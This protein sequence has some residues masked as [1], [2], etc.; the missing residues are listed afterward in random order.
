MST[1][2]AIASL[3]DLS[4]P[5]RRGRVRLRTLILMRWVAVAGQASAL[6]I[7][8]FVLGYRLPIW[9]ALATVAASAI[10]NLWAVVGRRPPARIGDR[11]AAL[12]FAYDLVQL[13][14]LLYL[15]G[16]LNNPFAIIILAPVTVSATILSRRSTLG[17]TL[18][19]L[20][21]VAVLALF[22]E[23][24][25]WPDGS[26][27]LQ[28]LFILG[29][30]LAL[31]LALVFFALYVFSVSEE[32]RRMSDALSATQMA[33]SREQRLSALGG[34]AAAAAHGLGSPLGTIAVI[35]KELDRDLPPD[36]PLRPDVELLLSQSQRCRDIL[37]QLATRPEGD[38]APPFGPL[39]L[40]ELVH[41]AAMPH[42]IE[43]VNLVIDAGP[44]G[45]TPLVA[46]S[47]ELLHGLANLIQNAIQFARREVRIAIRGSETHIIVRIVDD[48][49]GFDPGLLDHLGE[50][51]LSGRGRGRDGEGEDMGL[52]I[53][54]AQTLLEHTGAGLRFAN[55][56]TGGAEV[57]VTWPRAAL[58]AMR[59]SS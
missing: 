24:L 33:L 31:A 36:S 23:P 43:R 22:H 1:M 26:F 17:L 38:A 10:V 46:R 7:V 52:G 14:V 3:R 2:T 5:G 53:F 18:L 15:T 42:R 58:A 4:A 6:V 20:A 40:A 32:A 27:A 37:A 34:L 16:G 56:P 49:P 9:W 25:P 47:P 12:Y 44:E 21:I 30:A 59:Q 13:A 29:L 54:I 50:P 51:Y 39:P 45:G 57:E 19:A 48:G 41:V 35:A 28:P 11:D 55:R 8:H